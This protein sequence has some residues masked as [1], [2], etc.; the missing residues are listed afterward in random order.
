M[1]KKSQAASQPMIYI[2]GALAIVATIYIGYRLIGKT[3]EPISAYAVESLEQD[4]KTDTA[5]ISEEQGSKIARTY[6]T[7]AGVD[8]ICLVDLEHVNPVQIIGY[9]I[10]QDSV[11]SGAEK[12]VFLLGEKTIESFYLPNLEMHTPY[13]ACTDV[14]EEDLELQMSGSGESAVVSSPVSEL[15][16]TNAQ[17]GNLCNELDVMFGAGYK[18]GCCEDHE[19]CC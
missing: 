14:D 4:L 12:N 18:A 1:K 5:S 17:G 7:P 3:S 2:L 11:A 13:Y 16:C 15:Y 8:T 19:K 6:D 9:P 10:V